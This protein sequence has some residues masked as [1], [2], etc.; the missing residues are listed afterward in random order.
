LKQS[1][2]LYLTNQH[3]SSFLSRMQLHPTCRTMRASC[4][5]LLFS[6]R[7]NCP[8]QLKHATSRCSS[9][10]IQADKQ[11]QLPKLVAEVLDPPVLQLWAA[12]AARK[13]P[14]SERLAVT[15]TQPPGDSDDIYRRGPAPATDDSV[16]PKAPGDRDDAGEPEL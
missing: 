4:F 5:L 15:G 10:L 6:P 11:Q 14:S 3:H 9:P 13:S 12:M 16:G 8:Q 7:K 1:P 2:L